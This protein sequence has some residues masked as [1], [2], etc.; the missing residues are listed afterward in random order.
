MLQIR[1]S[2]PASES[3][4]TAK[5]VPVDT[6]TVACPDHLVLADLPVAKG[7]GTA[8]ATAVIKSVGRRSRRQLGERVHFCVRC[9][10]PVAIYGRLSPCEHAFCLDCARSHSL[11]YLCDERIQKIQTIKL[12][13]G[14]FICAAPRCLKSFLKKSEFEMHINDVH[15]DLLHPNKEKEGNESEAMSARKPSA[16]DTTVQAPLRPIFSPHSSSQV[17]DREDKAQLPQSRDQPPLKPAAQ[18]RPTPSFPGQAPDHPSEH[19]DGIPSHPFDRATSQ[20]HFPRQTFEGHGQSGSRQDS[21]NP[22]SGPAPPQYGYPPYAADGMQPYFGAPYGMPRP[23]S[24]PEGGQGQGSLLG[25]P[26]SPAGPMNFPQNYPQWNAVPGSVPLEPPMV[27]QGSMDGFMNVDPQGRGFFQN[28]YGQ[29]AGNKSLEQQRQGGNF[30]DPR[31]GKGILAPQ[32]LHL[33]P[34]PLR[35]PPHLPQGSSYSGDGNHDGPPG[36]SWPAERRDSFGGG[37]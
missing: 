31:D 28:D 29:N 34:P 32:P 25:F 17:H 12:M 27:S 19:P 30:V 18:Q 16:S 9:D 10:F 2:K 1:L 24:A 33:P 20:N 8:S 15:A 37:E 35:P 7:L 36:F 26:P 23:D 21:V 22:N 3:G 4:A 14:I 6:V 13:E 5:P 11:C